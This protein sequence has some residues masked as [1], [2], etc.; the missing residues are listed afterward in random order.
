MC[1]TEEMIPD[2]ERAEQIFSYRDYPYMK[3][4]WEKFCRHSAIAGTETLKWEK[5]MECFHH[6]LGDMWEAV[7]R[8]EVFLETGCRNWRVSLGKAVADRFRC[9]N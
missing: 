7:C 6:F 2:M 4:R 9:Y 3:K 8:D 5:E 1:K